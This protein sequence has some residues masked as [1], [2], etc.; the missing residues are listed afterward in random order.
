MSV[1]IVPVG[2]TQFS[3]LYTGAPMDAA[4]AGELLAVTDRWSARARRERAD[5]WVFGS[6]EL[7][8]LAG[9]PLPESIHY[10]DFAQIEN[11]VGAVTSL[12]ERVRAGLTKLPRLDGRRIGIVTGVSMAPLMPELLSLLTTVTGAHFELIRVENSLFGPTTTTAGLLVGADMRRAL[13]NR[14]DLDIALIPAESINDDGVFLDED[15][16]IAVRES[17]PMPVYPSYDFIDVLER[18]AEN[19]VPDAHASDVVI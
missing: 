17:L 11:G 14:Y 4:R 5:T 7:Y 2:L 9:R 3:H 13:T 6:D 12:R 16:F 8:L 18:E 1:A 15:S 10:G 19:T